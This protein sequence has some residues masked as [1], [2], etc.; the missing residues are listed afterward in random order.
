M[1]DT[2]ALLWFVLGDKQ[3]SLAARQ[4]IEN[5]ASFKFVSPTSYWEI[6]IK[7][8]IGKYALN[9]PYETFFDRAI[10][11]NGFQILPIEPRHTVALTT[12]PYHH[13]DP[14]DR[15]MIAQAMI[16]RQTI[17]SADTALDA[18]PIQRLW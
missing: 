2:H 6:A 7:I 4:L 14:F 8:S 17:V 3:L 1:L 9:E 16:E 13:R 15:L 5:S 11:Q 18:Y 12:L 10:R